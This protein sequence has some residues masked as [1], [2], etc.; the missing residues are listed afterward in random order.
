M[1]K[2]KKTEEKQEGIPFPRPK[3]DDLEH[4]VAVL[5]N[6]VTNLI[7]ALST[8]KSVKNI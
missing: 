2:A 1:A 7:A 8:S 5:E 4:R 6:R 3:T